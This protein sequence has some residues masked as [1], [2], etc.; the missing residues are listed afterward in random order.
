MKIFQ[1]F[2]IIQY[3]EIYLCIENL[4]RRTNVYLSIDAYDN[5]SF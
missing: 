5:T 4:T 1:L 3:K 2:L